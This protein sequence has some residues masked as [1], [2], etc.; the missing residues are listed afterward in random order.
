MIKIN[1]LLTNINFTNANN[2]KRVVG[3]VWH[4][5]GALG[6]AKA[7]CQY[8]AS[9]YVGASAHYYIGFVGEIWQSVEDEDIAWSVGASSYVHP[10]LRNSNT[11]SIELCV[12]K[13]STKTMGATDKDWYFEDATIESAIEL[14]KYLMKKYNVSIDNVVRHYDITGKICPNPLVYN[15]TKW[16]W[17]D[18][19][20]RIS[21]GYAVVSTPEVVDKLYRVRLKWKNASS[22]LGAYE[23]LENAKKN[24][25]AGY[26]VFDWNG[27]K[28]Y[29]APA[30][31]G[32]QAADIDELSHEDLI[33]K[34]GPLFTEDQKKTGVLASVSMAQYILESGWCTTDLAINANN[35]FGMKTTLSNNDWENSTWDGKSTYTKIT[36]EEYTPGVISNVKAAF[37]KYTCIEDS[38]ADH[39]AYL[40]GAKNGSKKR[41]AGLAGC[42]DYKKAITI[43]KN[44]GYATDSQYVSKICNIIEKW[45]LTK[46]NA[47][48]SSNVSNSNNTTTT[49]KDS[50]DV[51]WKKRLQK[52]CNSEGF[53]DKNGN[54]LTVDGEI[55]T[56][57]Y[58]ALPTLRLGDKNKVVAL[59][60]ERIE[61]KFG[62]TI[63]DGFD[64]YL[65]P[66]T[67]AS[68]K[69]LQKKVG[70]EADGIVG[71]KTWKKLCA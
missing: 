12:R 18:I 54:K 34:V 3:I 59:V 53:R 64:G 41:Y 11:I 22:Q 42:T 20:A 1:K 31:K 63:P 51:N 38:I 14:T 26:K 46:Y 16:K 71:K 70:L 44:G 62:I 21:K 30:K 40:L 47:T 23:I 48:S 25:P 50:D 10:Y 69:E 37:R 32:T 49:V 68:I 2:P 52:A 15:N 27:K 9:T 19:K 33:K 4:Y 43:I 65:G 45:G 13:K 24:C 67:K 58:S 36:K 7:N 55:G 39:S 35:C 6:G 60:Q 28:V 29:T 5:V 66:K 61:K 57:S 17:E 56:M 8:Y